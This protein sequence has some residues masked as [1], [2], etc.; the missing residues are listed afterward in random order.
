MF[1]LCPFHDGFEDAL[2]YVRYFLKISITL[3]KVWH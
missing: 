2:K 3:D 1:R